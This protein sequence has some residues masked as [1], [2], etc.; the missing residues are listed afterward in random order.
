MTYLL[1]WLLMHCRSL[2]KEQIVTK[3]Q[4]ELDKF[5][6]TIYNSNIKVCYPQISCFCMLTRYCRNCKMLK[7]VSILDIYARKLWKAQ[8]IRVL[9]M[10]VKP[11]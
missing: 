8:I 3:V 6:L 2:F 1:V 11:R 7:E 9:L 5:G 4:E 10:S